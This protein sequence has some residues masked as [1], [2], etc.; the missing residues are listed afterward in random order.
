MSTGAVLRSRQTG[1]SRRWGHLLDRV[2]RVLLYAI[3]I[4]GS[5][6]FLLPLLWMISTALKPSQDVYVFP[7]QFIPHSFI[8]NNFLTA[9]TS[10]NF[11]RYFWNTT[12]I[13]V[14]VLVGV[15]GSASL[16]AYGFARL[17]F[18]GRRTLFICVLATMML[19]GTVTLIPTYVLFKIF[20]WLDTF[21]PLIIP[22]WFGG[23]AFNIFL[24]RQFFLTI[25]RELEDAA[26]IDGARTFVIF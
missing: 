10:R 6:L 17:S 3:L 5:F 12:F 22:A 1:L 16:C 8:W 24:L 14:T 7:P 21:K 4:V 19:P 20:G 25:P 23:G 18:V 11:G 9:W 15:I 13:T 26:R 2:S